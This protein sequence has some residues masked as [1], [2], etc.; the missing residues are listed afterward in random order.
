MH[1]SKTFPDSFFVAALACLILAGP[2]SCPLPAHADPPLLAQLI[3]T[4]NIEAQERN[5][6]NG[7]YRGEEGILRLTPESAKS[8]GIKAV[9]NE[10]YHEAKALLKKAD[11]SLEKAQEAMTTRKTDATPDYHAKNIIAHFLS[12]KKDTAR[13][14]EKLKAYHAALTPEDD[15]RLDPTPNMKVL[16]R[17]LDEGLE[18]TKNRLRDALGYFYNQ[19]L[20]ETN[21]SH[22]LTPENVPFVNEVFLGYLEQA[23]KASVERF[24][25][26]RTHDSMNPGIN[27]L[28]KRVMG[29]TGFPYISQVETAMNRQ[30]AEGY[31][32][33]PLL[34]VA[35]MRRES[36]FDPLA[37]SDVGAAGLTQIMPQTALSLGME[38]IYM[39]AYFNEAIILIKEERRLGR[40]AME[41][42]FKITDEN[43]LKLA[44]DARELMQSSLD[45]AEKKEKLLKRYKR[46]LLKGKTDERLKPERAIEFG[47]RYFAQMMK[48]QDGDISLALASYNAGPHRVRKYKGIP[49]F[50]ETVHFRNKVMEFYRDYLE[51]ARFLR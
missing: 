11:K 19:C 24:D 17:L 47:Y 14:N 15:E 37:V 5:L 44:K 30:K 26:D 4:Y 39:P 7:S 2:L 29:K 45:V 25:L 23:P 22:Y 48:L 8:V 49:P 9:S 18:L 12:Y 3:I 27:D 20:G 6:V 40:D 42:L 34:F 46:D 16:N 41:A 36:R 35:L 32:I 10:T 31:I 33:D 50:R 51:M 1:N 13:A 28:W 38:Q 21:N 43:G